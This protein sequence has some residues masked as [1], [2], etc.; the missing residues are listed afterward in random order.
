MLFRSLAERPEVLRR[1]RQRARHRLTP[2]GWKHEQVRS[3]LYDGAT[4]EAAVHEM[5]REYVDRQRETLIEGSFADWV[6]DS[7]LAGSD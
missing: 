6:D 4:F 1:L 7:R 3:R 5:Q 2:A